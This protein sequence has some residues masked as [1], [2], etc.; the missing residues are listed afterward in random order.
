MSPPALFLCPVPSTVAARLVRGRRLESSL[1]DTNC[2]R[3]KTYRNSHLGDLG[4]T[5][6]CAT[7]S[8]HSEASHHNCHLRYIDLPMADQCLLIKNEWGHLGGSVGQLSI[9]TLGF[10]SGHVLMVHESPKTGS[11]LTVRS[12]PGILSLLLSLPL[13]L[14]QHCAHRC[15]CVHTLSQNK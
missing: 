1:E 5:A 4:E 6:Q 10:G 8:P 12:L 15:M 14:P 2:T 9:P 3:G 7:P 11:V 13:T